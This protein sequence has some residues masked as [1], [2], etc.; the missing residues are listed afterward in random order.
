MLS[1]TESLGF[2]QPAS[3]VSRRPTTT[4]G[5]SCGCLLSGQA[6][7]A[8]QEL[9]SPLPFLS[10]VQRGQASVCGG[11][12][13]CPLGRNRHAA[14]HTKSVARSIPAFVFL[15]RLLAFCSMSRGRETYI[16]SSEHARF[17]FSFLSEGTFL[18][19]SL[20]L[21]I[22]ASL[23]FFSFATIKSGK[24]HTR[25]ITSSQALRAGPPCT[26]EEKT[27]P[28]SRQFLSSRLQSKDCRK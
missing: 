1:V 10:L 24:S 23:S 17:C 22:S 3:Q 21:S 15:S 4:L 16:D 5:I 8:P 9:S 26:G 20:S 7:R 28:P 2:I 11:R 19:L 13:F 25:A 27:L 12:P 14:L 18:S 6:S